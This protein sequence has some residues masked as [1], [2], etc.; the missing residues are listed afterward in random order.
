MAK[1]RAGSK[2]ED[3]GGIM[4]P[5][6]T[7]LLHNQFH[8]YMHLEILSLRSTSSDIS[9]YDIYMKIS[10]DMKILMNTKFR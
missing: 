8:I 3:M 7:L 9:T 5:Q 1:S 6:L 4:G 10:H 2:E